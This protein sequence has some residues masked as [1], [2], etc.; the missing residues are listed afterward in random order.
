MPNQKP[1]KPSLFDKNGVM[2]IEVEDINFEGITVSPD[3]AQRLNEIIAAQER[4]MYVSCQPLNLQ[5]TV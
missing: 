5:F 4:A 2:R 3:D 1:T